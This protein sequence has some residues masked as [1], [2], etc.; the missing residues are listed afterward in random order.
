MQLLCRLLGKNRLGAGC[1]S[2]LQIIRGPSPAEEH[3][4]QKVNDN[5]RRDRQE[6]GADQGGPDQP[7]KRVPVQVVPPPDMAKAHA[8]G[9]DVMNRA[10]TNFVFPNVNCRHERQDDVVQ[11]H[12]NRSRDFV[13]PA[14]PCDRN[15]KKR[16]QTPE[17]RE[18]KKNPDGRPQG[19]GMRRIRDRHQ[20]QV[21]SREPIFESLQ[22]RRQ[23]WAVTRLPV[24]RLLF[25]DAT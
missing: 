3:S 4:H 8:S 17:R 14:Y 11:G 16:L 19:Y 24:S 23:A 13:R 7:Y 2:L 5:R 9:P 21:V 10:V 6:E 12:G 18:S 25:H 15:R 22:R 1:V 20:R